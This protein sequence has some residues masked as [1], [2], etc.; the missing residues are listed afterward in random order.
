MT[1][2]NIKQYFLG[3]LSETESFDFEFD[4]AQ[5]PELTEQAQLVESELID[6]YL[7][8]GLSEND[9]NLFE[10]NYLITEARCEKLKF[11]KEFLNSFK[12][13]KIIE[14]K[15]SIWQIIFASFQ[16]R[17]AFGGLLMLLLIGSFIFVLQ[18][19]QK[20]IEVVEQITPTP[21]PIIENKNTEINSNVANSTVKNSNFQNATNAKKTTPTPET[22]PTPTP[23]NI[24]PS[25]PTLATFML[26]PGTLRSNG[27]QFIKLTPS[28]NKINLRLS[29][30][31]EAIKY[32]SYNVI[33]KTADGATIST[34][35]NLK[36]LNLNLPA[37]K[38]EKRT[39]IIFVE[40]NNPQKPAESIAEY[41]FRVIR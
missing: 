10:K 21:T 40:G 1:D 3:E 12:A 37:N 7:R 24:E 33:I 20:K 22:T 35:S 39:Y 34:F 28:I 16:M 27:E 14:P 13:Q 23:E 19:W 26:L 15:V 41:T 9:R 29:L 18:N 5:N 31:K 38:L 30:P 32:Q 17:L 11:A 2:D 8:G 4:V 25:T 6:A 36:S